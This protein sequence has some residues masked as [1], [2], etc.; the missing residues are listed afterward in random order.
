MRA[1]LAASAM[2]GMG[3][4]LEA[5]RIISRKEVEILR[6]A[7]RRGGPLR[8]ALLAPPFPVAPQNG[9]PLMGAVTWDPADGRGVI[10]V[11]GLPV[12]VAERDYQLWLDGPDPQIP[13][14]CAVFH[15]DAGGGGADVHLDPLAAAKKGCRFLLI[16]GVKGGSGSLADAQSGGSIVLATPLGDG[17]ISDR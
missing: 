15:G 7:A 5:E 8:M 6:A 13:A 4:Q 9:V 3:N 14:R 10:R 2:Q 11:S 17:R 16:D 1:A 12:Q